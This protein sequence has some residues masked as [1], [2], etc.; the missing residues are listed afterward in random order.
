M[1]AH[2]LIL[3]HV[4]SYYCP[5]AGTIELIGRIVRTL[6]CIIGVQGFRIINKNWCLLELS[7]T[8][9]RCSKHPGFET[10]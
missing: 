8:K 10:K 1:H 3:T 7:I 9:T 6:S 2:D 5:G 4:S